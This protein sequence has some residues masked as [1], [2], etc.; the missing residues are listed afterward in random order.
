MNSDI[1]ESLEGA[2]PWLANKLQQKKSVEP[3]PSD[4]DPE[5]VVPET[6]DEGGLDTDC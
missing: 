3:D 5:P 1:K 6:K 2:D 4:S